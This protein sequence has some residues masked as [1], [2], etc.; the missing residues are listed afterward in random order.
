MDAIYLTTHTHNDEETLMCQ[1]EQKKNC[2]LSLLNHAAK[3]YTSAERRK[4]NIQIVFHPGTPFIKPPPRPSVIFSHLVV[5][6]YHNVCHERAR[7]GR[8]IYPALAPPPVHLSP[9]GHT[10]RPYLLIPKVA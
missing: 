6:S 9:T 4:D 10:A 2:Q 3:V 1:A 5:G 8:Q 7:V